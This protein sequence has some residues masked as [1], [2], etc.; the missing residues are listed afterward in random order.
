MATCFDLLNRKG[1]GVAIV[2]KFLIKKHI[3]YWG[4]C[5]IIA[6]DLL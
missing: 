6:Q 5:F 4:E 3:E 2:L 1:G